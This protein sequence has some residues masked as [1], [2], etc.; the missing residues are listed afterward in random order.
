VARAATGQLVDVF[1]NLDHYL[2][3]RVEAARRR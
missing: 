3:D 2:L 1:A